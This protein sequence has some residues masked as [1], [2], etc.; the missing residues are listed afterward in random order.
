MQP[1]VQLVRG[2]DLLRV[3]RLGRMLLLQGFEEIGVINVHI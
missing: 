3:R 2:L 1:F